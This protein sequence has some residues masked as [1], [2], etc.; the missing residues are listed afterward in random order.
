MRYL[1]WRPADG[2]SEVVTIV[3]IRHLPLAAARKRYIRLAPRRKGH[4]RSLAALTW[5]GPGRPDDVTR[6]CVRR[7]A[8]GTKVAV[9]IAAQFLAPWLPMFQEDQDDHEHN[10]K[11]ERP[12]PVRNAHEIGKGDPA[13]AAGERCRREDRLQIGERHGTAQPT[14][15]CEQRVAIAGPDLRQR[16]SR[17]R[18]GE[19]D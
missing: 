4:H 5:A 11:S 13:A 16:R 1:W 12:G 7:S 14:D 9:D 6:V 17:A 8:V 19:C 10:G 3:G 15:E 2:T 18:P